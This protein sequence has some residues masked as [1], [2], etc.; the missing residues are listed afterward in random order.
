VSGIRYDREQHRKIKTV[1]L[2]VDGAEWHPD[3]SRIPPNKRVALK[4]EYGERA[5][6]QRIRAAGGRW[7][8]SQ[9]DRSKFFYGVLMRFYKNI[10][11]EQTHKNDHEIS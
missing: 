5:L 2:I 7:N 6:G 10:M 4:V 9:R 1:E 8:H 11:E 3:T